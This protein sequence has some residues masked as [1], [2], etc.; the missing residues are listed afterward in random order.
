[1]RK[2]RKRGGRP[3]WWFELAV[4]AGMGGAV[5]LMTAALAGAV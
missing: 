5:A 4:L 3:P 2:H 1:M